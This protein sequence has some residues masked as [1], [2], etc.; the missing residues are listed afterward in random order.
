MML[1]AQATNVLLAQTTGGLCLQ[2]IDRAIH[3]VPE[4]DEKVLGA[5]LPQSEQEA[6]GSQHHVNTGQAV[7]VSVHP[8]SGGAPCLPACLCTDSGRAVLNP[9][10]LEQCPTEEDSGKLSSGFYQYYP[11]NGDW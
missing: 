9:P 2:A 5:L 1:G 4:Y 8:T 6:H 3:F 11:P 7:S 10:G